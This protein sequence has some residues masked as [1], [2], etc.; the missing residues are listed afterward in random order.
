MIGLLLAV[1]L[2]PIDVALL[3]APDS[4]IVVTA[5]G[6]NYSVE[7]SQARVRRVVASYPCSCPSPGQWTF[8]EVTGPPKGRLVVID[9]KG[10]RHEPSD[11]CAFGRYPGRSPFAQKV[12][13]EFAFYGI[14]PEDVKSGEWGD[15]RGLVPLQPPRR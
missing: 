12:A 6:P 1:T 11:P 4:S 15:R 10:V 7:E 13:H 8:L 2:R 14:R 3:L 5:R 9:G